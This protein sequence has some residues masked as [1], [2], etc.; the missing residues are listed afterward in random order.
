[1]HSTC[2]GV[3]ALTR[4]TKVINIDISFRERTCPS[5]K[6]FHV[7][8]WQ[9]T[10]LLQNNYCPIG[11]MYGIVTFIYGRFKPTAGEYTVPYMDPIGWYI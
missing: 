5:L 9:D 10:F 6:Y 3:F 4:A 8:V 7:T 1:M 11:S 2:G